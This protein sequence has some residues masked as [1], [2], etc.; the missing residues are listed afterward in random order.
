MWSGY[1]ISPYPES[2]AETITL[3]WPIRYLKGMKQLLW[4]S[5][6]ENF[7]GE[8]GQYIVL[9]PPP[10]PVPPPS[11]VGRGLGKPLPHVKPSE[12]LQGA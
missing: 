2:D 6:K 4:K 10:P 5:L 7:F 3:V 8:S 1:Q 11:G 12:R 9:S